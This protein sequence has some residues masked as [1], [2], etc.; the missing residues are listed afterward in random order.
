MDGTVSVTKHQAINT[1]GGVE[2]K[3]NA[4]LILGTRRWV[5]SFT[6]SPHF[7]PVKYTKYQLDRCGVQRKDFCYRQYRV[8]AI[9][10]L[11]FFILPSHL[12]LGLPSGFFPLKCSN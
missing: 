10:Q 12:R 8:I 3:L 7:L 2:V 11:C 6:F 1:F 5:F 9:I 4:F